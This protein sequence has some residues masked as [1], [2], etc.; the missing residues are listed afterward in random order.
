MKKY[1]ILFLFVPLIMA[2]RLERSG[3]LI[4][5]D[6][7]GYYAYAH[8]L[9]FEKSLNFKNFVEYY[10]NF[11]YKGQK[12]NRITWDLK[13]LPSGKYDSPWIIGPALFWI[14][15]IFLIDLIV[16]IFHIA[17]GKFSVI[18]E[19]GPFLT[20][21]ILNLTGIFFLEKYL[22]MYFKK[23]IVNL[24]LLCVVFATNALFY[25]FFEPA[26]S[27][28]PSF[29]LLA[30][31]LYWSK[32][33]KD[34]QIN[35]LLLGFLSGILVITRLTNFVLLIPIFILVFQTNKLRVEKIIPIT[36]GIFL[37]LV[38]QFL[39]QYSLYGSFLRNTYLTGDKG[40]FSIKLLNFW[41]AFF[42]KD[43][44]LFLW[45][46]FYLIGIFGLLKARNIQG[47]IFLGAFFAL[48]CVVSL[49]SGMGSAGFGERM[50]YESIIFAA[51]GVA[52]VFE[53]LT[54][55]KI[56]ILCFSLCLLNF[57]LFA[58]FIL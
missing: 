54:E 33:F 21:A 58:R 34:K 52:F 6:G 20:G 22:M 15:S 42:G 41:Q 5:G 30:F 56:L 2:I 48:W 8:T 17:L 1:I 3:H 14:P 19:F 36:A 32:N 13:K 49:W 26:L 57:Y 50:F 45:H 4:Y 18:Y 27:H 7:N 40:L 10:S 25:V 55:K 23:N 43:H 39:A 38:P 24:T 35:Y 46:P 29:F 47:K 11:Q 37:G 53:S 31:L 44:G 51:F 16:K 12:N 9:Y 28:Q